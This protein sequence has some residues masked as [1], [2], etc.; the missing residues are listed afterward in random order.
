MGTKNFEN[1]LGR[2][3]VEMLGTLAIIGVLSIG[4]IAGYS[5]GMDKYRANTIMNDVNL[6]AIDLIAQV[7]KGGELSL[8]EWP[9]KTVGKYDI[10]LE[11]DAE[12]NTTDG[13]IYVDKVESRVC[14]ILADDLLP[15]GIELVINGEDY[16]S[17]KCGEANKMVFYYDAVSKAFGGENQACVET[18]AGCIPCPTGSSLSAD[19]TR[20]E[21]SGGLEWDEDENECATPCKAAMVE[22]GFDETAFSVEG[23]TIIIKGDASGNMEITTP[24]DMS[25]CNLKLVA[26]L[27]STIKIPSM[28][29]KSFTCATEG[30]SIMGYGTEQTRL[31][32]SSGQMNLESECKNLTIGDL[33]ISSVDMT[34]PEGTVISNTILNDVDV[35]ANNKN[36]VLT[37]KYSVIENS[38]I[39]SDGAYLISESNVLQNTTV[40]CK[41][42]SSMGSTMS[43]VSI[44]A[45]NIEFHDDTIITTLTATASNSIEL[46]N[47]VIDVKD[48]NTNITFTSKQIDMSDCTTDGDNSKKINIVVPSDDPCN[49]RISDV[50]VGPNNPFHG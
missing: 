4:G 1:E 20:C 25:H 23:N 48:D 28:N 40:N 27:G 45:D 7:N 5:Y 41:E 18:E 35:I 19:K 17:G 46:S 16:T 43:G 31:S 32:I 6:R 22:A 42:F 3:M 29:V 50:C 13:G 38:R 21:C 47:T 49:I 36:D 10:G 44:V 11:K 14:E 15:E 9:T 37:V 2:S 33:S 24:V 26:N 39:T 34:V 12:T 30:V 8:A